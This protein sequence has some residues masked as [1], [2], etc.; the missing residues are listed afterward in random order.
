MNLK[1]PAW[2]SVGKTAALLIASVMLVM[3]LFALAAARPANYYFIVAFNVLFFL[4]AAFQ[5]I[6]LFGYLDIARLLKEPLLRAGS[7]GIIIVFL[8]LSFVLILLEMLSGPAGINIV[9]ISLVF[10]CIFFLGLFTL[11]LGAGLIRIR[12]T[13]GLIAM[14]LGILFILAGIFT[15]LLPLIL[16]AM[17]LLLPLFVIEA[18]FFF[19]IADKMEKGPVKVIEVKPRQEKKPKKAG[20]PKKKTASAKKPAA[21]KKA[22]NKGSKE[23]AGKKARKA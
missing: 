3:S 10:F 12:N 6:V 22:G 9:L 2:C 23:K 19:R 21:K 17:L 20:R 1:I 4:I 15:I 11:L 18:V 5:V 14:I 13:V 8:V 16:L 7:L